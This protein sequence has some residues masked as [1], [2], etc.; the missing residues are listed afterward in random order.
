VRVWVAA[1]VEEEGGLGGMAG[2]AAAD[3]RRRQLGQGGAARSRWL[4]QWLVGGSCA[5]RVFLSSVLSGD[6]GLKPTQ[7]LFL[8]YF[9]EKLQQLEQSENRALT[10]VTVN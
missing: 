8:P 10:W 7:L 4:G 1:S 3:R 5:A 6:A 2:Q 9:F